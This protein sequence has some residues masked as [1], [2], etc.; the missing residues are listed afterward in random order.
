MPRPARSDSAA[1]SAHARTTLLDMGDTPRFASSNNSATVSAPDADE[2]IGLEAAQSTPAPA[3]HPMILPP[4]EG[5]HRAQ[6]CLILRLSKPML[7]SR[8]GFGGFQR[9]DLVVSGIIPEPKQNF[10]ECFAW[11]FAVG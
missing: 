9:Q 7:P 2:R 8:F 1:I 6:S 5:E 10:Q 11:R 4:V 3:H